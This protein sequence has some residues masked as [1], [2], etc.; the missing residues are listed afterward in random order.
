MGNRL[1]NTAF[2]GTSTVTTSF[3][4]NLGN[5]LVTSQ[6]GTDPVRNYVYDANGNLTSDGVNTYAYDAANRLINYNSGAATFAY[7][8]LGDRYRQT[9]GGVQ[10]DYLLDL[11]GF[12]QVLGEFKPGS[13]TYYLLGLDVIGQQKN[14]AWSYFGYDGLGSTRQLYDNTG[15]V[16]YSA[17]YE[18]YGV[19]FE[20]A[21]TPTNLASRASTP[22][23]LL[24]AST[25]YDPRSERSSAATV[26]A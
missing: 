6:R 21:G 16:G 11:N 4:Y 3:T 18:P 26:G 15:V 19:P 12:T 7:N 8:G 24:L 22:C 1:A 17:S 25:V 9:V 2:D 23:G 10:T 5:Q 20:Q 13:N 14:S